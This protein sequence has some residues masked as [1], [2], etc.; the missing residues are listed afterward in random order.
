MSAIN[1]SVIDLLE[2]RPNGLTTA[3]IFT[4]NPEFTSKEQVSRAVA[5]L[6]MKGVVR[7]LGES[8]AGQARYGLAEA[9]P[10]TEPT[11][12]EDQGGTPEPTGTMVKKRPARK[13]PAKKPKA[14]EA[15]AEK[16]KSATL[17]ERPH[18]LPIIIEVE[19]A[20][21]S[22]AALTLVNDPV[23]QAMAQ[24]K[25]QLEALFAAEQERTHG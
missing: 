16:P 21:A 5:Y 9:E 23:Y 19:T 14:E 25:Q 4:L 18:Y 2:G 8:R 13:P 7:K 6:S 24:A 20:M 10:T 17:A 12:A 1:E 3:E 11:T 15:P 22:Y